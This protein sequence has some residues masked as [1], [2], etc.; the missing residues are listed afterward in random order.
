MKKALN[1]ILLLAAGLAFS[2]PV[3]A[4]DVTIVGTGSGTAVLNAVGETF[5]LKNPGI[6]INVPLSIGCG[7]GIK[8]VGRD[9]AKIGRIARKIRPKEERFKLSYLLFCKMPI[10]FFVNKSVDAV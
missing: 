8:A 7:G 10:C 9:K 6:T 3:M 5:T 2:G 4:E 1:A